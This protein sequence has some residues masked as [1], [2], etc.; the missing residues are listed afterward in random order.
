MTK[1]AEPEIAHPRLLIKLPTVHGIVDQEIRHISDN[2]AARR[3]SGNL[4]APKEGEKEKEGTEADDA[5]PNRCANEV[6]G[7]RVVHSMEVPEDRYLMVDEAVHQIFDEG[8]EY[9]STRGGDPPTQMQ[10]KAAVAETIEQQSADNGW[11]NEQLGV[12]TDPGLVH[13]LLYRMHM[14]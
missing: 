14:S 11:I 1:V 7:T 3:S 2:Q 12:V 10:G 13:P 5:D 4:D 8:P 6:S 9:C